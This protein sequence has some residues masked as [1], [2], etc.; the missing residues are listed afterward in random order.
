MARGTPRAR[1]G[2][3][4]GIVILSEDEIKAA[5]DEEA[6]ARLGIS[7]ELFIERWL[8]KDLPDTA[9]T[10]E[11]GMLVRLLDLDLDDIKHRNEKDE[12]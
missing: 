9:A 3:D 8:R 10:W 7:G 2:E 12:R 5:I 1:A 11:I 6:R 4:D